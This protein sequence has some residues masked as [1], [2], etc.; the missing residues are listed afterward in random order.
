[1]LSAKSSMIA[2]PAPSELLEF[3]HA[4]DQNFVSGDQLGE[5]RPTG[6]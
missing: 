4:W 6:T 3:S 5:A 2:A 1:M